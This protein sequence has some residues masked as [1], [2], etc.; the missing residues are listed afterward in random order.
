MTR[1][2]TRSLKAGGHGEAAKLDPAGPHNPRP[3][4]SSQVLHS[5]AGTTSSHD[6]E[7][8]L[9]GSLGLG[10]PKFRPKLISNRDCASLRATSLSCLSSELGAL[11]GVWVAAAL[12]Y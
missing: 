7:S 3:P 4:G 12:Y 11:W 1:R 10:R 9:L 6:E 2:T 8:T 5:V